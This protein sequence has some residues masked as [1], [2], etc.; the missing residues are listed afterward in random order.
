MA[1]EL[2]L[3]GIIALPSETDF[4]KLSDSVRDTLRGL[5]V[6]WP[7][8]WML[9]CHPVDGQLPCLVTLTNPNPSN[10]ISAIRRLVSDHG[11]A[12]DLIGLMDAFSD[13]VYLSPWPA[14]SAYLDDEVQF[15]EDGQPIPGSETPRTRVPLVWGG[16]HDWPE[17]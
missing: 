7:D 14:L 9:N 2:I 6:Q 13:K 16:Y 3:Q 5:R 17:L 4:D 8:K 15:D 11:L 1:G 10:P 12:W